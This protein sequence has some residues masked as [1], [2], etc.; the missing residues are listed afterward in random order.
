[1]TI[2]RARSITGI[3]IKQ[4]KPSKATPQ[5]T[6]IFPRRRESSQCSPK[7]GFSPN[8]PD[9]VQRKDK[10]IAEY[11]PS[12]VN[13]PI[14]ISAYQLTQALPDKLKSSL[15]SIEEIEAELAKRF[16]GVHE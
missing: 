14:G 10:L 11:A 12:D 1:M 4:L 7:V 5:L 13:K 16:G 2:A 6:V 15:P 9:V 8:G 3:S